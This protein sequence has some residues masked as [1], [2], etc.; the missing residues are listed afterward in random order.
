VNFVPGRGFERKNESGRAVLAGIN[1]SLDIHELDI[2]VLDGLHERRRR[3]IAS[4]QEGQTMVEYGVILTT[5]A[6][7]ATAAF[8][9]FGKAIA[10]MLGPV[11]NAFTS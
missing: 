10:S 3:S 6:L 9:A 2:H 5:V 8:L 1:E 7:L 11:V 4:N